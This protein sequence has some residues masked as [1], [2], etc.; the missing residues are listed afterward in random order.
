MLAALFLIKFSVLD[1]VFHSFKLAFLGE[2]SGGRKQK[3]N[4]FSNLKGYFF[5]PFHQRLLLNA[6]F[7][8]QH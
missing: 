1:C 3:T 2:G 7:N 5:P 4:I 6:V 8:T